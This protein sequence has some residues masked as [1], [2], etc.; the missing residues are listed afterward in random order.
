MAVTP[1][2]A[3][4]ALVARFERD[5]SWRAITSAGVEISDLK[6]QQPLEVAAAYSRG[7]RDGRREIIYVVGAAGAV[8][9]GV[10]IAGAFR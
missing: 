3:A 9:G 7:K 4:K 1:S 10:R 5:T 8:Y 6:K 2:G